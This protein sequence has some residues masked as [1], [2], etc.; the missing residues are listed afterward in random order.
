MSGSRCARPP[1][2]RPRIRRAIGKSSPLRHRPQSRH[3]HGATFS[4]PTFNASGASS[5]SCGPR[6]RRSRGQGHE[7]LRHRGARLFRAP[8]RQHLSPAA[9]TAP[10]RAGL[11]A[12]RTVCAQ[13]RLGDPTDPP[14]VAAKPL[15]PAAEGGERRRSSATATGPDGPGMFARHDVHLSRARRSGQLSGRRP[16]WRLPKPPLKAITPSSRRVPCCRIRSMAPSSTSG[17]R[18][19]STASPCCPRRKPAIPTGSPSTGMRRRQRRRR[20]GRDRPGRA[21]DRRDLV[22][23]PGR[24]QPVQARSAAGRRHHGT[25]STIGAW[26]GSAHND[27]LQLQGRHGRRRLPQ[28]H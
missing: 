20:A 7:H 23:E 17:C 1:R 11:P 26:R 10:T 13:L 9:G 5:P 2:R 15:R 4:P 19:S 8:S 6:W 12:S 14:A 3:R 18:R 24:R 21:D 28:S 16:A 22:R 25:P 27:P